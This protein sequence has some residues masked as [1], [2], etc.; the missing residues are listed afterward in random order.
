MGLGISMNVISGLGTTPISCVPLLLSKVLPLSFGTMAFFFSIFFIFVEWLILRKKFK[1]EHYSQLIVTPFFGFFIDFGMFL[2]KNM[3]LE[4]Y[5]ERMLILL[6]GCLL[7]ALGIY[8]QVIAKVLINSAEGLVYVIAEKT[9]LK[10]GNIKILFDSSLVILAII[11]SL[12]AFREIRDIR[13]GTIIVALSLGS[14]VKIYKRLFDKI[15]IDWLY[16]Y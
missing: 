10:F 11:I 5:L 9:K 12:L 1:K 13:E 14:L 16:K 2:L 3:Q 4:T 15:G 7:I 8:F 6:L